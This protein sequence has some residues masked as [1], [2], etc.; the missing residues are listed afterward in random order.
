MLINGLH[1]PLLHNAS[2]MWSMNVYIRSRLLILEPII[3]KS[4]GAKVLNL[5]LITKHF[6]NI[7]RL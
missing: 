3:K 1:H 2:R 4:L 5:V 6:S 7:F